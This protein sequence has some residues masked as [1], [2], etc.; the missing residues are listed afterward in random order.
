MADLVTLEQANKRL[1]LPPGEDDDRRLM[2]AQAEAR[3]LRF[4]RQRLGDTSDTWAAEVD[5]WTDETAP[6]EVTLAILLL[7]GWIY[8]WRGD[9]DNA[10]KVEQGRLPVEVEA[11]LW[12]LRDPA[13]A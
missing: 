6:P 12:P 1:R 11:C 5:A 8:R 3:V 2:L 10:P 13:V 9:D 4:V 7:F